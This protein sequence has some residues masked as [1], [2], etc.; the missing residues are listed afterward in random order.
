VASSL[1][2]PQLFALGCQQF[3]SD[4]AMKETTEHPATSLPCDS[5][6]A[7]VDE[8]APSIGWDSEVPSYDGA[9]EYALKHRSIALPRRFLRGRSY[10]CQRIESLAARLIYRPTLRLPGTLE[11]LGD[12]RRELLTKCFGLEIIK[13]PKGGLCANERRQPIPDFLVKYAEILEELWQFEHETATEFIK[14]TKLYR[15]SRKSSLP[16]YHNA[17]S[18]ELKRKKDSLARC[19]C[20]IVAHEYL[21]I[22]FI[23]WPY[24]WMNFASLY[25]IGR[26]YRD[27][28][29]VWW[30]NFM[31]RLCK[32][33]EVPRWVL[34][35]R[36]S[37]A[38]VEC[39][40]GNRWGFPKSVL[41]EFGVEDRT[42]AEV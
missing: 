17:G 1:P 38:L 40:N 37:G 20:A 4:I 11:T 35:E 13:L 30:V 31:M 16:E 14:A 6:G 42:Q 10:P 18:K 12:W 8:C 25:L 26:R 39:T 15:Q 34:E 24:E 2:K 9:K 27:C 5:L 22:E 29:E 36:I 33:H 3:S 28:E 7:H 19:L 21:L 23:A 41:D 32:F